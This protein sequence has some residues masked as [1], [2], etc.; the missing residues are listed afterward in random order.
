MSTEM[1]AIKNA[2]VDKIYDVVCFFKNELLDDK[3]KLLAMTNERNKYREEL[4]RCKLELQEVRI[5][6]LKYRL[7][8]INKTIKKLKQHP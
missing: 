3:F 6:H 4:L 8:A 2:Y 7:H 5:R 1:E